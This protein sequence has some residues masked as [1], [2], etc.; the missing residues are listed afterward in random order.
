MCTCV[1][2]NCMFGARC[3]LKSSFLGT[4]LG[5]CKMC[6]SVFIENVTKQGL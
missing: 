5:Q 2:I 6:L 1:D 3:I 4:P